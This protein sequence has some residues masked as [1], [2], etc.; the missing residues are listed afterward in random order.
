VKAE[1]QMKRIRIIL[2]IAGFITLYLSPK[3]QSSKEDSLLFTD[4]MLAMK[5]K[6]IILQY[7][8]LSEAEK[9]SFWPIY[10]RYS[11]E[12]KSYEMEYFR[13]LASYSKGLENLP[14][15]TVLD[16]SERFLQNDLEIARIRKQYYKKFKKALSPVKATEFMQLD[17]SF[18]TM[19][20]LEVQ[21]APDPSQALQTRLYLNHN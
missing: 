5:K 15:R 13:L 21:S 9:S 20:R 10:N 19:V 1:L 3:A 4:H 11:S 6:A 2:L 7:F 18:R 16:L 8:H 14:K 17:Q 12:M